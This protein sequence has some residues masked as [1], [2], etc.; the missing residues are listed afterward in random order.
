LELHQ[1]KE[2]AAE[3]HAQGFICLIVGQFEISR[4]YPRNPQKL[5]A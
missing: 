3:F 1:G 4:W 5:A 2:A